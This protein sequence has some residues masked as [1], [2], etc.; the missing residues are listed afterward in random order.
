MELDD[1]GAAVVLLRA[2]GPYP[3]AAQRAAHREEWLDLRRKGIGASEIA[4]ILGASPWAS[5]FSLWWQKREGW[6]FN[7]TE[8]QEWG[9]RS[10]QMIA[11]KFIEVHPELELYLPHALY[12][13]KRVPFLMCSPD[14]L[15]I[16]HHKGRVQIEPVELKTDEAGAEW[17]KPGTD[18]VPFHYR[19]QVQWQM[20]VFGAKR[21]HLVRYARKRYTEY[22]IGPTSDVGGWV[23]A[24]RAFLRSIDADNPPEPD[25]HAATTEALT[26]LYPSPDD[27]APPVV[28]DQELVDEYESLC[29][30]EKAIKDRLA[31][32]RNRIRLQLGD[33][34]EGSTPDGQIFVTRSVYTRRGYTVGE[35]KVDQL[36]KKVN[37]GKA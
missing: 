1:V 11:Q 32:V 36:R 6:E 7:Q 34:K 22:V 5:R 21:G 35:A 9:L 33:G 3:S 31:E 27:K 18:E 26:L 13:H 4:V 25:G 12:V 20:A 14:R 24:A 29:S 30:R 8:A 37:N 28:F 17:G 23:K 15:A 10:E 16:S 2:L 19:C